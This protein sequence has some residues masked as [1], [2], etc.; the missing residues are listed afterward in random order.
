[1]L[2]TILLLLLTNCYILPAYPDDWIIPE[3]FTSIDEVQE[4]IGSLTYI[5][6]KENNWQYPVETYNLKGGD[7]ED[8]SL[9]MLH[10]MHKKLNL[11]KGRI[12]LGYYKDIGHAWVSLEA[13]WFESVG[14]YII[15]LDVL[16]NYHPITSKDYDSAMRYASTH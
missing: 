8:L 5:S 9:L 11:T 10:I 16:P 14:G 4:F 2:L 1:M 3:E 15:P 7:C 6:D 12:Q 13:T